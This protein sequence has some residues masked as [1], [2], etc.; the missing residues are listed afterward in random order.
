[1]S[2]TVS[3]RPPFVVGVAGG[4][5]SGKT[6]VVQRMVN[7]LGADA[8]TVIEHDRYYRHLP[9]LSPAERASLN[10]DHPDSLDTDLLLEHLTALK[11]GSAVDAP[12]YDFVRHLRRPETERL[13][14]R[15][16]IIVEGILVLADPRLV[17][18]MDLRAFVDAPDDVRLARRLVRDTTERGRDAAAVK[19]QFARTV[20]PMHEQFVEPSR[21][22]A[23]IIVPEGGWNDQAIAGLV[24]MILE[25]RR[26][27]PG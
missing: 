27:P 8:V 2:S 7:V 24:R 14:P 16:T 9:A 17:R 26:N 3:R 22:H 20:R 4:S 10:Y 19:R 6:T 18:A 23:D 25:C 12:L 21:R 13:E 11:R 5:S 1:M 15:V